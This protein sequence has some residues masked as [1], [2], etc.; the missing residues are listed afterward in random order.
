VGPARP[1][2][3]KVTDEIFIIP[4]H[5]TVDR[6]EILSAVEVLQPD[7]VREV[8]RRTVKPDLKNL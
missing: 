2:T 7:G 4:H 3:V 1:V 6:P 8:A 5:L